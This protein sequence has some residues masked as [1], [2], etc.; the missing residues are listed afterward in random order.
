M[1]SDIILQGLGYLIAIYINRSELNKMNFQIIKFHKNESNNHEILRKYGKLSI[2]CLKICSHLFFSCFMISISF[3]LLMSVYTRSLVLT[4]GFQLPFINFNTFYGWLINLIFQEFT[5]LVAYKGFTAYI[6]MYFSLFL[7]TCTE[8]DIIINQLSEFS[9]FIEEN[10]SNN[11][12]FEKEA[13]AYLEDIIKLHKKN[14]LFLQQIEDMFNKLILLS[15]IST[16]FTIVFTLIAVQNQK[17][18]IPG[19]VVGAAV[20]L[21]LLLGFSFGTI[22]QMKVYIFEIVRVTISY[23]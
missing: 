4:F 11:K 15:V 9:T 16:V 18:F 8:I 20:S 21:N 14:S 5:I 3:G 23:K 7:F 22:L 19:Y 17:S 10:Y 13:S 1:L 2:I 6:R 12:N